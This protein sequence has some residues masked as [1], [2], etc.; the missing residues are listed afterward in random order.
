MEPTGSSKLEA[1]LDE[2]I[3]AAIRETMQGYGVS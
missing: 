2:E 3:N 1:F